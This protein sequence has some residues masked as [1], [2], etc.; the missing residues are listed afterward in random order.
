MKNQHPPLVMT[1][2]GDNGESSSLRL[3]KKMFRATKRPTKVKKTLSITM[4]VGYFCLMRRESPRKDG[5]SIRRIEYVSWKI[6]KEN[7]ILINTGYTRL[8]TI[9]GVEGGNEYHYKVELYRCLIGMHH[10]TQG[11]IDLSSEVINLATSIVASGG[12]DDKMD[13]SNILIY[14]GQRV[15]PGRGKKATDQVLKR[16]NL[17]LNNSMDEG[18]P[19][20]ENVAAALVYDG[21]YFVK[22]FWKEQGCHGTYVFKYKLDRKEGQPELGQR[23]CAYLLSIKKRKRKKECINGCSSFS[24]CPCTEKYGGEL[25]FNHNWALLEVN[26]FIYECGRSC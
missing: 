3:E 24:K 9:L 23:R 6:I 1:R 21:L 11:G 2:S 12:Y 8:G 22:D 17:A 7:N 20:S 25:P 15:E 13:G 10:Q 18:T 19:Q 4:Y 5:A 26:P 14:I 16:G